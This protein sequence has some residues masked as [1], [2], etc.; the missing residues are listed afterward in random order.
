MFKYFR[1]VFRTFQNIERKRKENVS[2]QRIKLAIKE[3]ATGGVSWK[4][5]FL[6]I[7]QNSQEITSARVSFFINLQASACNFIKKETR[8]QV[9]FCEFCEFFKNISDT[10]HPRVTASVSNTN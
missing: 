8:A 6:K 5:V 1:N 10:K 7:L 9:F 3:A 4:K 2:L